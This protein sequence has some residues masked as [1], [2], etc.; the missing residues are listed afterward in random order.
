MK[1]TSHEAYFER[2]KNKIFEGKHH[3]EKPSA[4]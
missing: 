3:F 1:W 2:N 4:R